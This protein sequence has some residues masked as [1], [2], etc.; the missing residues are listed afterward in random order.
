MKCTHGYTGGGTRGDTK[1]VMSHCWAKNTFSGKITFFSLKPFFLRFPTN[2]LSHQRVRIHPHGPRRFHPKNIARRR[3]HTLHSVEKRKKKRIVN[4]RW[5]A[6]KMAIFGWFSTTFPV[7]QKNRKS[8]GKPTILTVLWKNRQKWW[9][10]TTFY[11]FF[12]KPE[13][14]WFSTTF[15]CFF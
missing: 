9:K 15:S 6:P 7:F 11:G 8:G 10:T 2:C 4:M 13:K 12:E 3:N 5:T 14:W 1:C